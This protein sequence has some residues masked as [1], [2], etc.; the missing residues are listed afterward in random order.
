MR[1]LPLGLIG[2][3]LLSA[4]PS[5]A[6]AQ[7]A[8]AGP[9]RGMPPAA[10]PGEIRGRLVV[11]GGRPVTT[12]SIA[13]RRG[14]E[15][16]F[17]GG[18][19][20]RADGSFVVDGLLPGTY[21]VRV[22]SLGYAPVVK[23][24]VVVTAQAP[25]VDL[26]TIELSQVA[27]TLAG[28]TVVAE[29]DE[30]Q[31][32]PERNSYSVKNMATASGGTAVDALRNIPSVEVDGSNKVSL[33]GSD[34]VVVQINGRTSPLRGEQLGTFLAQLPANVVSRIEVAM[35]PSA[36]ED[37]EGTAGIINLVLAQQV[38]AGLSGGLTFGTGST[39]L[40]NGSG[41]I[42]T[43]KGP[44]TLFTSL[45]GT[46]DPRPFTGWSARTN[47]AP[48][49][50]AYANSSLDGS[51]EPLSGTLLARSEYKLDERNALSFD[52]VVSRSR[53]DR[54]NASYFTNL[55][56][57]R[58]TLGLFNQFSSSRGRNRTQDYTAAFRRTGPPAATTFSAELR[59]TRFG[60]DYAN[61]RSN[62]LVRPDATTGTTAAP[63]MLD[64]L[65]ANLPMW[66]LQGDL[67]HP[68]SPGNK[69]DVGVKS[70]LRS[71]SSNSDLATVDASSGATVPVRVSGV[72]YRESIQALYGM[73]SSQF[74]KAQTQLGLRV[75]NSGTALDLPSGAAGHDDH[76]TS[77]FPNG[78]FLYNLTDTRQAR[79]SY[80]RRITRPQAPQLDP[81]EFYE[82][83][84]M[85]FRG[86]PDLKPEYTD[87]VELGFQDA[88]SW[89]SLQLNP[90]LRQTAN[91]MRNIRTVDAQ[92][93]TVATFANVANVRTL[94]T[95]ANVN[96]R[97]GTLSV[98][99]GGGVFDYRSEAGALSTHAFSWNARSNVSYGISKV[100][101][102]QLQANY[103]ARTQVEGGE[104]LPFFITNLALRRKLWGEAGSLT[105]R[106]N[107]VFNTATFAVKTETNG[108]SETLERRFG[109]RGV[110]VTFSRTFG[111]QLKLR[112]RTEPDAAAPGPG[113]G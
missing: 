20:P 78:T 64:G 76:Y 5:R 106:L 101:D 94:G 9:G 22:R 61:V 102:A 44:L 79:A 11:A 113:T 60:L 37:P 92:G 4:H 95:D 109:Q 96:V 56:A 89:G 105:L 45:S 55:D 32:S 93:V 65:H 100:L 104:Q 67:T 82:N 27:T 97:R 7:G 57:A 25:R 15:T 62:Q 86:N 28:Q 47:A 10:G 42:G 83:S 18:T 31:L 66:V 8:P 91:A 84:R 63:T 36:K 99:A 1:L 59:H 38:E 52:A 24:D 41:N 13:V 103:R 108:V 19:L 16:A 53:M 14:S 50:P 17:V 3:V 29:R 26:G 51:N 81:S 2:L 43:Q 33:R 40:A 30:I 58:D 87:A 85:V 21:S 48:T 71:L 49:T 72:D 46:R 75:E 35:N 112:P 110:F 70:T 69:L 23:N 73:L 68:F 88:R 77:L 111:Q 39:G 90:Y 80:S 6:A 74:G 107:D 12:G 98:G 34:N 54:D